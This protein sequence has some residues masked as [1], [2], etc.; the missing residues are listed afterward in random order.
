MIVMWV[1]T[2]WGAETRVRV[3]T[4]GFLFW[5]CGSLVLVDHAAQDF[6]TL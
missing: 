6:L 2:V 3:L 4:G 1:T 5:L